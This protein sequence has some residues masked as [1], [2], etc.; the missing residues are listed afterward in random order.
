MPL[1]P[2]VHYSSTSA[3]RKWHSTWI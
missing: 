2:A 1:D 3:C